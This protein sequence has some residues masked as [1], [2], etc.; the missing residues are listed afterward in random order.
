M[1]LTEICVFMYYGQQK[2]MFSPKK[3]VISKVKTVKKEDPKEKTGINTNN[4]TPRAG[5]AVVNRTVVLD[6]GSST[7]GSDPNYSNDKL[8]FINPLDDMSE[9]ESEDIPD[10]TK[11]NHTGANPS[12]DDDKNEPVQR[13]FVCPCHTYTCI[14]HSVMYVSIDDG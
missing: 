10:A 7:T 4:S 6:D 11:I 9:Y 13:H 1:E 5:H 8:Q 3:E 14:S 2:A 12:S